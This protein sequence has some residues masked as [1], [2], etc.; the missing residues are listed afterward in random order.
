MLLGQFAY[1]GG[2]LVTI[3]LVVHV[4]LKGHFT[5]CK[6]SIFFVQDYAQNELSHTFELSNVE[7]VLGRFWHE[8][9]LHSYQL[10]KNKSF[11]EHLSGKNI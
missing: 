10:L 5:E 4:T 1:V 2:E 3:S 8:M 11:W 9:N 7:G 6:G